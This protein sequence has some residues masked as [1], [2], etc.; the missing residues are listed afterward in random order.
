MDPIHQYWNS[1][2]FEPSMLRPSWTRWLSALFADGKGLPLGQ[3]AND[4]TKQRTTMYNNFSHGLDKLL[5]TVTLD[6]TEIISYVIPFWA[7]VVTNVCHACQSAGERNGNCVSR[8]ENGENV[9]AQTAKYVSRGIERN[10]KNQYYAFMVK[11]CDSY[12]YWW[13][14]FR[15]VDWFWGHKQHHR[16]SY[17]VLK[18]KRIVC[19]SF[20]S[21][22]KLHAYASKEP[23]PIKGAFTCEI[24]CVKWSTQAEFTVIRGK[25]K[26][27]LGKETATKL[28]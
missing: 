28:G 25:G 3:N 24:E 11:D 5:K 22:K 23:L 4:A 9:T 8:C 2:A 13:S 16:Q 14:R 12:R 19:H 26:P 27:L 6:L 21:D 17:M 1:T 15:H 10:D 20:R 7:N 18:S